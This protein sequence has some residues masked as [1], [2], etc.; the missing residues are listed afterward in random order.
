MTFAAHKASIERAISAEAAYYIYGFGAQS[1]VPALDVRRADLPARRAVRNA[2]HDRRRDRR[3]ARAVEGNRDVVERRSPHAPGH[4]QLPRFGRSASC[5]RRSP[6]TTARRSRCS[7]TSISARAAR[8]SRIATSSRTTRATCATVCTRSGDRCTSSSRINASGY[9]TNA[10]AGDVVGYL[11]G[12]RPTPAGVDLVKLEA[13]RHAIPQCA[14]RVRRT[15]EMGPAMPFA[16][17]GACGCYY[18]K[19]ATGGTAASPARPRRSAPRARRLQLR[20]LRAAVSALR[21]AQCA[22]R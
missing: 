12:T 13:Q 20:I 18:E 19:V 10:K 2:A 4:G 15:Q 3:S 5:R 21:R 17:A 7:R 9:P 22:S 14:M 1:A 11:A 6:R 8:S 16:P